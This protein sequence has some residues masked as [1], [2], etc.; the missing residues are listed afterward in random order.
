MLHW[1]PA[2]AQDG[3]APDLADVECAASLTAPH[4][5]VRV[6]LAERGYGAERTLTLS[7]GSGLESG[8]SCLGAAV[9]TGLDV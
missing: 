5:R 1:V 3:D 7:H 8:V 9:G 2:E 4:M 6:A